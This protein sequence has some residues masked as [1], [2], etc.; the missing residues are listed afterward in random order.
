MSKYKGGNFMFYMLIG[1]ALL[2]FAISVGAFWIKLKILDISKKQLKRQRKIERDELQQQIQIIYDNELKQYYDQ[3]V[4]LFKNLSRSGKL[5]RDD[6]LKFKKLLNK[7]LGEFIHDYDGWY[8]PNDAAEIYT[9]LKSIY[10]DRLDWEDIN[11]YL[12]KF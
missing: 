2:M 7:L 9:K 12:N 10:Y 1:V 5:C 3:A 6:Y 4:T 8:Y 11:K